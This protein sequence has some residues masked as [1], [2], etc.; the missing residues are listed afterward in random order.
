MGNGKDKLWLPAAIVIGGLSLTAGLPSLVGRLAAALASAAAFGWFFRQSKMANQGKQDS[1]LLRILS[2]YR[3][4]WMNH[5]QV[6]MGYIQLGKYE[7]LADYVDKIN[8]QVFQESYLVKMGVPELAVYYYNFRADKRS[9]ELEF[10]IEQEISLSRLPAEGRKAVRFIRETVEL[11]A[12]Q[13]GTGSGEIGSLSLAFGEEEDSMLL[14]FVYSGPFMEE[15]PKR[16][17]TI[18]NAHKRDG[19]QAEQEWNEKGAA[20]AVRFPFQ[21]K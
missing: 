10:E 21:R 3:H 15:A 13:N 2:I 18:L 4:D 8:G 11:F 17:N 9:L 7:R 14:D 12:D 16:L 6:L 5:I 19:V 1:R 20:I